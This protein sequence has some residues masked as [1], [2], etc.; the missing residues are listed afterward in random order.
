MASHHHGPY[1]AQVTGGPHGTPSSGAPTSSSGQPST[2]GTRNSQQDSDASNEVSGLPASPFPLCALFLFLSSLHRFSFFF[3]SFSLSLLLPF[4]SF[5]SFFFLSHFS[6]VPPLPLPFPVFSFTC[7]LLSNS[8]HS[9]LIFS[10]PTPSSPL[11]PSFLFFSPNLFLVLTLTPLPHCPCH[12]PLF[13]FVSDLFITLLFLSFSLFPFCLSHFLSSIFYSSLLLSPLS[14]PLSSL[15]SPLSSLLSSPLFY[16]PY[17]K[18]FLSLDLNLY[19]F[20][21]NVFILVWCCKYS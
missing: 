20:N 14:S 5:L 7:F 12:P 4:H 17:S 2:V 18:L 9:S 13:L 1:G 6:L 19:C 11:C 15:L 8:F 10:L 3:L 16:C 21:C